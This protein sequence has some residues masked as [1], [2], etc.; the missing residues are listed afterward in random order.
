[1]DRKKIQE[2]LDKETGI[3]TRRDEIIII[4]WLI[5]MLLIG[6]VF[7]LLEGYGVF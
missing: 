3:M 6:V 1:M 5:T 4:L 7:G 2:Y